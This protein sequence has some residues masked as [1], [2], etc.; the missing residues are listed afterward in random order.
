MVRAARL[1]VPDLKRIALV[2]D[3]FE[4]DAYRGSYK[5]ELAVL[6]TELE[7]IDLTGLSMIE[8]RRRVAAL[9]DNT[10]VLYTAIFV[11]GAGAVYTPQNA[12]VAVAE[13][14]NRPIVIDVESQLGYGGAGG[15]IES[16]VSRAQ[17][18]ARLAVR[19]F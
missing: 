15:F 19:I 4:R 16:L 13:A 7:V 5:R 14:T 3:P 10:A 12:L 1:L 9:P 17:E 8:I 2:G 6:A 18:T 11:D